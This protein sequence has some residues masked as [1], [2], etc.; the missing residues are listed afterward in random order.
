VT[1]SWG[2]GDLDGELAVLAGLVFGA[3]G[4]VGVPSVEV[5]VEHGLGRPE[6]AVL[7]VWAGLFGA[8]VFRALLTVQAE[9]EVAAVFTRLRLYGCAIPAKKYTLCRH[10]E[11]KRARSRHCIARD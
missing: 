1:V 10:L 5:I 4:V 6:L 11:T 7:C 2:G 8:V 3:A 9:E